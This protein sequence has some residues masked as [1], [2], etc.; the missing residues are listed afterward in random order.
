MRISRTIAVSSPN[1]SVILTLIGRIILAPPRGGL[2][3]D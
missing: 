3:S 2:S 1:L